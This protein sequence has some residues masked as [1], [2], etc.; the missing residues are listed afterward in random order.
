MG[1]EFES[2][3][4][5]VERSVSWLERDGLPARRRHSFS[6]LRDDS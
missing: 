1:F 4:G 3:L 6:K 5:A 2:H